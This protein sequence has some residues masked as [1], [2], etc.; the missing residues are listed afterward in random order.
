MIIGRAGFRG[1]QAQL[2][3]AL[4]VHPKNESASS[5]VVKEAAAEEIER[6]R[7]FEHMYQGLCK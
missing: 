4:R 6:L 3:A 1:T 5:Y 7:E 2:L